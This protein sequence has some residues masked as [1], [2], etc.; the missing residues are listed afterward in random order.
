MTF[1]DY[2]EG[3]QMERLSAGHAAWYSI[4]E[5]R[6][7][8]LDLG[9]PCQHIERRPGCDYRGLPIIRIRAVKV[10]RL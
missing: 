10:V 7:H 1:D 5:D 4:I 3:I 9:F 8:W 2:L 6:D